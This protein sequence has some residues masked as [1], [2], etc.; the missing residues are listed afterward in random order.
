MLV[1]EKRIAL[2]RSRRAMRVIRAPR[3]G[4]LE[5]MLGKGQKLGRC[6]AQSV[7]L[8][9]SCL[10][11]SPSR[12]ELGG[13]SIMTVATPLPVDIGFLRG[14]AVRHS[15]LLRLTARASIERHLRKAAGDNQY[16]LASN[17]IAHGY[18]CRHG[19]GPKQLPSLF[20]G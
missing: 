9:A 13:V 18:G 4:A 15:A 6:E 14:C 17:S 5:Q 3:L 20:R 7:A 11:L 8:N 1:F 2:A 16:G 12:P 19:A 10:M